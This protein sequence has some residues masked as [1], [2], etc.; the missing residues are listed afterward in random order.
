MLNRNNITLSIAI[1]TYN[2]AYLLKASVEKIFAE[3]DKYNLHD[4]VEIVI[5]DNAS[6]DNT[7]LVVNSFDSEKYQIVYNKNEQNLG[8]IKNILK[9]VE[10]S[11]GKIWMFYGDDDELHLDSLP[12]LI[13]LFNEDAQFPAYMFRQDNGL[14]DSVSW[15]GDE[16]A[17]LSLHETAKHY[18]YYIGNAGILAVN[19]LLAKAAVSKYYA[20]IS[21]TCWPQ[22]NILFLAAGLSKE[23]KSIYASHIKSATYPNPPLVV[24]NSYYM[25]ETMVFSQIRSAID[26]GKYIDEK[27]SEIAV[28]SV[29]ETIYKGTK[30]YQDLLEHFLF[31]DSSSEKKDFLNALS[32]YHFQVNKKYQINFKDISYL[33]SKSNFQLKLEAYLIYF[34]QAKKT[35]S[36]K[37]LPLVSKLLNLSYRGYK[38]II[39]NKLSEKEL[40]RSNK[41]SNVIQSDGDYF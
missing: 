11:N 15:H 10:L 9:L 22:T 16:D 35:P 21:N 39:K 29:Y 7:A 33:A 37:N 36:I 6:K 8:V 31:L 34:N 4:K 14:P 41:N 18:F 27:F 26:I 30:Y 19:T 28:H 38:N 40:V 3:I 13:N 2:R 25:F 1:P 17:V 24:N 12:K 20:E 5:S 23:N 32:A